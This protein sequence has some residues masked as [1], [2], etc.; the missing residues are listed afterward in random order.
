M[1]ELR[2]GRVQRLGRVADPSPKPR[3]HTRA[4]PPP[5]AASANRMTGEPKQHHHDDRDGGSA[6]ATGMGELERGDA[7]SAGRT[8]AGRGVDQVRTSRQCWHKRSGAWMAAGPRRQARR[9]EGLRS[10]K[11]GIHLRGPVCL[12]SP[13]GFRGRPG[14]RRPGATGAGARHPR[15]TPWNRL[16]ASQVSRTPG[17]GLGAG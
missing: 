11:S 17:S 16:S 9:A 14:G 7:Q 4:A 3:K 15:A 10:D 6:R 5:R 12:E 8:C 2:G 13:A 1:P